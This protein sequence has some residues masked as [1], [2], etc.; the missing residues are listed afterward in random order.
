MPARSGVA[1][2]I[3]YAIETIPGTPATPTK[4]LPFSSESLGA[5]RERLE[6]E[7]I[8][9]D[10]RFLDASMYNGG[11]VTSGGDVQHE[12]YNR[13]LGAQFTA[14]F[15]T[16]QSSVGPVNGKYTHTWVPGEPKPITI[17]KG[18]PS[19]A[20]VVIPFT[21]PGMMCSSW[22]IKCAAGEIATIANTW[23]GT[24]EIHY[25]TVTDGV[26]TTGSTAITSAT[27]AFKDS[28]VGFPI[29]GT[30]I[31]A[32]TTLAAVN[33]DG[34]GATLSA[35]A[36]VTGTAVTFTIGVPLAV[37][38][39]PTGIKPFKF[40]HG[41]VLVAGSPVKVKQA[42]V[43]GD[44]GLATDRF[45]LGQAYAD[46]PLENDL[47]K[48]D[49]SFEADFS[50]VALYNRFLTGSNFPIV[51]GFKNPYGDSLELRLNGRFDGET[52]KASGRDIVSQ[53]LP[54]KCVGAT[55]ADAITAVLVSP[56]P[57]P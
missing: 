22:E 28:D 25:R 52:P 10:R 17:Q 41:Y 18:I 45:F 46:P 3:G 37:S 2:Q 44:N 35:N 26:T 39:I 57:T 9:P 47:H 27:A 30:G 33:A 43:S 56:D 16:V 11:K 21:Y 1:A 20:G 32:G 8:V 13:G 23:S 36:T 15:G 12:L 40:T 54:F 42:T 34:M 50:S 19:T 4:F 53:N 29:T 49:G 5:E 24:S 7:G 6:S 38:T 51:L 14:M 55:D 48:V 31:P